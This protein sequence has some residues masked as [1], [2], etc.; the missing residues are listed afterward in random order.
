MINELKELQKKELIILKEFKTLC[1]NN[2]LTYF[3]AYGTLLGAVRHNGFIPW[4]DDIDVCMP[5]KDYI[6]FEEICET[7][8]NNNFFL[9]TR[10]TQPEAGLTYNKLRL[11]NTTLI[12]DH[13]SDRDIHHGINIDIYPLYNVPDSIFQR[14]WQLFSAA[15]YMLLEEA[16][17]PQNHGNMSKIIAKIL[18]FLVRGSIRRRIKE[19]C[20]M[21]MA[22]YEKQTTQKKAMLFG[23]MEY[24]KTLYSADIFKDTTGLLF[25]GEIYSA[26]CGY[27]ACLKKFYGDYMKLP[28]EEQ[29]VAKLE[30]IVKIDT[31]MSYQV[32]KGV[33]YCKGGISPKTNG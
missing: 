15:V 32:Y 10:Y 18:L 22:S 13:L 28:P 30:H 33:Y 4:D 5:F 1:E 25:E 7:Q 8:L 16:R 23:N 24:C 6:R 17:I 14:K 2:N 19:H 9:Q 12:I 3:I 21:S 26:P 11:N 27:D 29:R 20:F 31:Q